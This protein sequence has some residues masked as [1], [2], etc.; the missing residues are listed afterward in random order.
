MAHISLS[1]APQDGIFAGQ[2]AVQLQQRGLLIRP[3][4]DPTAPADRQTVCSRELFESASHVL[5]ILSPAALESADLLD[6][7]GRATARGQ[8]IVVILYESCDLPAQLIDLSLV[9]FR[10]QF[11]MAVEN[12]VQAL[13]QAGAP[14]R[15]LT[16]E[17]PPPVTKLNLLPSTL[18]A[19]RC[20]RDDRLQIKYNLPM[21]LAIGD[22]Q[23][24]LPS[25]L[26][27]TGFEFIECTPAYLRAQRLRR[28]ALFDPRRADHTLTIEPLTGG[29]LACYQMTRSQV[30]HWFPAHYRVLDC[31]A[32]ALYRFLVIE[33]HDT[34][35]LIPVQRQVRNA[36]AVS[37]GAFLVIGLLVLVSVYLILT[38]VLGMTIF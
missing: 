35:M 20:W 30:Y 24:R 31:E 2:L 8:H 15:P 28:F 6:N 14:T 26:E 5:L 27:Q 21:I 9:D 25:F 38:D 23:D 4:P 16:V 36:L 13:K 17:F 34:G 29:L 7:W 37:W 1:Y 33:D 10:R 11:L 19:E 3:V 32:A 22:L 12:L 18:P